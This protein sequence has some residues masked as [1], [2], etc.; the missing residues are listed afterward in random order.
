M[1]DDKAA[2]PPPP[3]KCDPDTDRECP[4]VITG[5]VLAGLWAR[6]RRLVRRTVPEPRYTRPRHTPARPRNRPRPAP[7]RT[8]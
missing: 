2:R 6:L 4:D 1:N 7:P 5:G 3:P 8:T